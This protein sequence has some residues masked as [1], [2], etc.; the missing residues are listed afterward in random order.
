VSL[1]RTL[2]LNG[3]SSA[4][5]DFVELYS[6]FP[7]VPKM[8]RRVIDW[9]LERP[10]TV[11]GGLTFG[12]GPMG[13]YMSHAVAS[14]TDRL[15]G[16]GGK[17]LLFANGGYATHNHAIILSHRPIPAARLPCDFDFQAESDAQRGQIPELIEDYTGPGV[18]ESY[19][20][21]YERDGRAKCGVVVGRTAAGTRFLARVP[22][23]DRA[24]I[25]FLTDGQLE[26]VGTTGEAVAGP[27][28]LRVWRH[29]GRT[30]APC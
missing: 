16:C 24:T 23:E 1:R 7:C 19:T 30:A 26:P 8:A 15:R 22:A 12:G 2:D 25:A 27:E 13:N 3:F 9:P 14:L 28:G 20:V 10:A 5:L 6:C 21:I 4:E 18:I 29:F 11:F 17:G